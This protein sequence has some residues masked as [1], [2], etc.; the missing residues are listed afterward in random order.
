MQNIKKWFFIVLAIIFLIFII[1]HYWLPKNNKAAAQITPKNSHIVND[2]S[3]GA[4]FVSQSSSKNSTQATHKLTN[5]SP[6][7]GS[8]SGGD[9]VVI[10]GTHLS[11]ITSV[12]FG[13]AQTQITANSS[14]SITVITPLSINAGAVDVDA[15][16]PDGNTV[17]LGTYNYI[18]VPPSINAISP[19]SGST[20]GGDSIT[21]TGNN[22]LNVMRVT[23][24]SAS[25]KIISDTTTAITVQTPPHNT[26]GAVNVVVKT[27]G[28][29]ATDS[30]AY[31]YLLLPPT[32]SGISPAS[33]SING[34][35]S[36]TISGAHLSDPVSVTFDGESAALITNT[37]SSITV[38]TPLHSAQGTVDVVVTT[39]GGTT[40]DSG[41][42]T[43]F[44]PAPII[45]R[46]SATSGSTSGGDSVT[47][48]GKHLSD[49]TGVTFGGQSASIVASTRHTIT[50]TT[51][52][53]NVSTV[54]VV[55]TT[56]GGSATS[57]Q[58]YAYVVPTPTI[59]SIA[60]N[61]GWTD[62][63]ASITIT[64]ANFS[65]TTNVSFGGVNAPSFAV[66]N[67][68]TAITVVTPPHVAGTYPIIVSTAGSVSAT[69]NANQYTYNI[70][71]PTVT[72]I[73]PISGGTEGGESVSI[74]GT[75]LSTTTNVIFGGIGVPFYVVSPTE[76]TVTTPA[77]N[78]GTVSV[79]VITSGGSDYS[80]QPYT[81][82]VPFETINRSYR[83][84]PGKTIPVE[85]KT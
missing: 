15:T 16:K 33:G 3:T 42:Y 56:K 77:S 54:N 85:K 80:P 74:F 57:A 13:G 7:S 53:N 36:V 65:G 55:V 83:T 72:G 34:G 17:T 79:E 41:A 70:L 47:I 44:I 21:I 29:N 20:G 11:G 78:P 9:S 23:F 73:T 50:V 31:H 75:D 1:T 71:P 40:T 59:T 43:Y 14:T 24:D 61:S 60:P 58:T 5:I 69:T 10:A 67:D 37:A 82:V 4:S 45:S 51:P 8:T 52:P 48:F 38:T 22:L 6:N 66:N 39:S 63:G 26:T 76:I 18:I 64:G 81:Y 2:A 49:A 32:I 27:A 35:N 12:T 68:G 25:S 19:N 30:K 28:G 84:I 62:G 46:I